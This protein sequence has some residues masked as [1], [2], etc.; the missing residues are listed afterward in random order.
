MFYVDGVLLLGVEGA[1]AG[2]V[3]GVLGAVSVLA[4]VVLL[5]LE[6]SE[7]GALLLPA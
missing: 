5:S 2:A 4:G 3:A 1:A 6:D 7:V